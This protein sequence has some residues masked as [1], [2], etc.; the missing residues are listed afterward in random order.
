MTPTLTQALYRGVRPLLFRLDPER[1]HTVTLGVL[2]LLQPLLRG[3][4]APDPVLRQAVYGLRFPNPIGLAAGLDKNAE[5]PHVWAALGFGF[6]E[7]GTITAQAQP[8]NPRPRLFRLP[9]DRALINRLG[10]NNHGAAAVAGSLAPRLRARPAGIPLGLNLGK[11][12]AAALEDAIEDYLTSFRTLYALGDYF[13]VNVSSPNTPNL[14]DLQSADRLAPLLDA[15]QAEN[16]RLAAAQARPM[17]P[18]L[19]KVA[20]DLSEPELRDLVAVA[21]ASHVAGFV[22]SNTTV[23]RPSLRAPARLASQTGGLSGAPLR[24]LATALVATLHRLS[25]GRLPIIGVGGV[26]T[27]ADAYEKIRAGASLVQVYT[28]LIYEGP[29]LPGA[30]CAGLRTLLARDGFA[31]LA[32]AVGTATPTT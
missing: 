12:R 25:A 14:R 31:S 16:R 30:L 17:R 18:L 7:L 15:L 4:A 10:F 27:P 19:V 21:E 11:S 29:G 2:R 9:A 24:P 28:G 6:A 32:A 22:A 26:F 13:V 1:A 20:P 8:G 5:A 3:S 23:Q